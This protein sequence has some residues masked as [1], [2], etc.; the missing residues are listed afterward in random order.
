MGKYCAAYE[1]T[2]P[3]EARAHLLKNL[4]VIG[5]YGDYAYGHPLYTWDDGKRTLG[6]CA[7]CGAF[8]L[9]QR[10]EYHNFSGDD[11]Y[12]TDYFFLENREEA[13]LLNREYDGLE[14]ETCSG[15]RALCITNGRL[16]WHQCESREK[17]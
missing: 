10:S 14:I 6:R 2:D 16:R 1:I 4:K 7:E 11:S 5:D 8:V 3:E 17:K 9:V 13:D 15:K 12:Y